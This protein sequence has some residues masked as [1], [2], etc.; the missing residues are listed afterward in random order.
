MAGKLQEAGVEII[1]TGGTASYLQAKGIDVT[2]VSAIT[3]FPEIMDGRVKTLHP[4]VHGGILGLRD[5]P[6]HQDEASEHGI[7][8]IDW[9]IVNLYPFRSTVSKPGVTLEEA[10]EQ[11]DI[12]GPSM[13]RSAAKNYRH[14][15]I[16]TDPRQYDPIFRLWSEGR[17]DESTRLQ[18]ALAAFRH[19][20]H[21]DAVI[22]EYLARQT[23]IEGEFPEELTMTYVKQSEL[24]YGENPHQRAALYVDPLPRGLGLVQAEQLQGKE[25]S[26]NNLNDAQAAWDLLQEFER[27]TAVA[28]KHANPCGVANGNTLEEAYRL[29]YQADPVSIFGGIV[30]VNRE[31]DGVTAALMSEIFLEVILAPDFSEEALRVLSGKKNLRLIRMGRQTVRTKPWQLKRLDDGLLLQ[32]ADQEDLDPQNWQTAGR[33]QTTAEDL[34]QLRF[35]WKVVKHVKSNAIVVANRFQTLGIGAGQMN[36][37]DAARIALKQAEA[38]SQGVRGAYLASDAFFPFGDVVKLAAE[39]GIRAIVQPGGSIRD[40]ESIAAADEAGIAM[41]FTGQRHFRH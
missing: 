17:L 28:V 26:Y 35:A 27:P 18:L 9:V 16:L 19:T 21:Y 33:H 34:E 20:A 5:R 31:L 3:G 13:V 7:A 39:F 11:I 22:A 25:L 23:S 4:K 32:T 24:R 40:Q 37:I 8:W 6:A 15:I 2:P 30:A 38:S 36:R 1:S 41:M 10:V 14:V 12:G 29:A